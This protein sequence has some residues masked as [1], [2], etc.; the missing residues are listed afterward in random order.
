MIDPD[1]FVEARAALL[2]LHDYVKP[3]ATQRVYEAFDAIERAAHDIPLVKDA[4]GAQPMIAALQARIRVLEGKCEQA[5][6]DQPTLTLAERVEAL[7]ERSETYQRILDRLEHLERAMV[8]RW[9]PIPS[10][11]PTLEEAKAA[12]DAKMG[13]SA[14][15]IPIGDPRAL[16]IAERVLSE[17]DA[18]A[19][20]ERAIP[21]N[22]LVRIEAFYDGR[23]E[24]A[25][26]AQD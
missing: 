22:A 23:D 19:K 4:S 17:L 13:R 20:A 24:A 1:L 7:E 3:S 6:A 26:G 2:D 11:P 21:I 8:S 9:G 15:P 16:A 25:S 10:A 12:F 5:D 14:M 18:R